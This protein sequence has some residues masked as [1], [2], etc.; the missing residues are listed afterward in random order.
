[1]KV[2]TSEHCKTFLTIIFVAT[3]EDQ[4]KRVRKYK[5]EEGLWLRDFVHE[6][7]GEFTVI[8][9]EGILRMKVEEK[10]VVVK[11]SVFSFRKFDDNESQ[12]AKELV[13]KFAY[14]EAPDYNP[15]LP[16]PSDEGFRAIPNHISYSFLGFKEYDGFNSLVVEN[17]NI[18]I[19]ADGLIMVMR[20][21][22]GDFDGCLQELVK[23][24]LP[25]YISED[26][27]LHFD[28]APYY[29][30]EK[31]DIRSIVELLAAKGF[32]Y[33]PENCIFSEVLSEFTFEPTDE[34]ILPVNYVIEEP[35]PEALDPFKLF[36]QAVET[37]D[38]D[39][40]RNLI[41]SDLKS[42][43][44][45]EGESLLAYCAKHNKPECFQVLLNYTLNCTVNS[46]NVFDNVWKYV[47]ESY[48]KTDFNYV[49]SLLESNRYYFNGAG[50]EANDVFIDLLMLEGKYFMRYK[51][52]ADQEHLAIRCFVMAINNPNMY[53]R[54][55]IQ[56][57]VETA[58]TKY[59][60]KVKALPQL[61][62]LLSADVVVQEIADRVK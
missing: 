54:P 42:T 19:P 27:E 39:A 59:A 44:I 20:P 55:V 38:A 4:W 45:L 31:K 16:T 24:F 30:G 56:K 15:S 26:S 1:M 29:F 3:K 48:G 50:K 53:A 12:K 37:D 21:A 25:P 57:E 17:K 23:P 6:S 52:R 9:E 40:L 41:F 22:F 61:T 60:A 8:E 5:N 35:E 7:L 11:P 14:P 34:D 2:I 10:E 46:N 13:T 62:E 51:V 47:F 32:V 58:L 33:N 28:I 49:E 18:D 36:V 43:D